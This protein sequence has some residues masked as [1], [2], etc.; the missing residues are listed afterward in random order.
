MTSRA[1][2]ISHFKGKKPLLNIILDGYGL[3]KGDDTD[4]VAQAHTPFMDQLRTK[5]ANSQL[6]THG[7]HVGLPTLDNLGGSEVGHLT[8]GA[9]MLIDQGSTLIKKSIQSGAFFKLPVL[10]EALN[11]AQDHALHLLGLL[12]DG[13]VHSHIDHFKAIIEAAAI[14]GVPRLYVHALLDGRD[15]GV[16]TAEIYAQALLDLFARIKAQHPE[17]DYRFASAGGRE[18]ITMDRDNN[19]PKVQRGWECHVHGNSG[20]LFDGILG[21]IEHFRTETP[22][23]TDQD[24]PPFNLKG[25]DGKPVVIEDGDVVVSMNFRGDRAIEISQ[26]FDVEDFKGFDRGRRPKVY[27]AG[28]M[29]YDEDTDLPKNKIIQG[30]EVPNPFGKRLL[31]LGIRQ[32]R[33]AETQK[34][35]HVTFFFNG[36]YRN[37]LDA[38]MEEY[39]LIESD[40]IDSFAKAPKMKAPEVADKA[41]EL[42]L[43]GR[44]GY[45]LINFANADMVGHT[46]DF[47]AAKIAVETVDQALEKICSALAQVGG[48]AVITADHGNADEM[49]V[50]SKKTGQMEHSAKHS[51]NPVPVVLFDPTYQGEYKLRENQ[52]EHPNN[53]SMIAATNYFLLGLEPPEDLAPSLFEL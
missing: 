48:V 5:Y 36:G 9:G 33:L 18:V 4:A 24:L 22:G 44:F 27:F 39:V 51:L 37:P 7:P 53:L 31:G 41:V 40:K 45:G 23:I 49:K 16:Q 14:Q 11:Q 26:A 28:M 17:Y 32:F 29:V 6:L 38:S 30:A 34:Y 21:A 8:L 50:L 1:N 3:G 2:L 20:Q 52:A 12:S 25:Q 13:N 15:V 46:G 35:A 10:V 42:I 19:W 43:S 47:E